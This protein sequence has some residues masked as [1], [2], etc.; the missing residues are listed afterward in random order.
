MKLSPQVFEALSS[1]AGDWIKELGWTYEEITDMSAKQ[2][3]RTD[4]LPD[5]SHNFIPTRV[6]VTLHRGDEVQSRTFDQM[7]KVVPCNNS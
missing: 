3:F 7:K 1:L 2:D 6:T 4:V 5:G